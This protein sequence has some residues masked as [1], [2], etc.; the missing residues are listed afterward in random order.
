LLHLNELKCH[1]REPSDDDTWIGIE[2]G[3]DVG[4]IAESD[5]I[6]K[7]E[8]DQIIEAESREFKVIPFNTKPISLEKQ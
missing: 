6:M 4:L 1:L 7:A 3:E 5:Q 8:D 2:P